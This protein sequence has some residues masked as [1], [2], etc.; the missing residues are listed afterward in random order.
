M[1]STPNA[2][3]REMRSRSASCTHRAD[4][5][6]PG[7]TDSREETRDRPVGQLPAKRRTS[8]QATILSWRSRLGNPNTSVIPLV[9]VARQWKALSAADCL[10]RARDRAFRVAA[11]ASGLPHGP[12]SLQRRRRWVS[13]DEFS[14]RQAGRRLGCF[15]ASE[16]LRVGLAKDAVRRSASTPRSRFGG[17]GQT[18]VPERRVRG[19]INDRRPELNSA[20][21]SC[22]TSPGT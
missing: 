21:T 3:R 10:E 11:S 16:L 1:C 19:S 4:W 18:A 5:K 17:E 20:L 22:F 6:Q 7:Q 2:L 13:E 15:V 14:V 8:P 12:P 9:S